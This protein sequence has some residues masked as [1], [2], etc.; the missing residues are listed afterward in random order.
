MSVTSEEFD[1]V[2]KLVI[3]GDS[4]SSFLFHVIIFIS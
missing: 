4:M 1:R 3:V 2:V